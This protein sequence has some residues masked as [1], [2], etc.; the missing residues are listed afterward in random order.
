MNSTHTLEDSHTLLNDIQAQ[1]I[2]L[3]TSDDLT[4]RQ[5]GAGPTD[6]K[7]VTIFNSTLMIPVFS[8]AAKISPFTATEPTKMGYASLKKNG[9]MISRIRFVG[10]PKFYKEKTSDGIPFWK[11]FYF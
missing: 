2:R 5:G 4:V 9:E 7:A 3:E 8:H 6:H 10:E 11:I 1:G